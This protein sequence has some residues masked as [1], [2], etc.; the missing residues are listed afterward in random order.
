MF[1]SNQ[2]LEISG[3]YSQLEETLYFILKFEGSSTKN[4]CYQITDDGKY[5]L[6]W[7]PEGKPE[8][9]WTNFQFDFDTEIVSKIIIQTLHKFNAE[10]SGYEW[11]D[12]CTDRGFLMK[13]ILNFFS[14]E[15]EGIK[16]P[17]YGI[18]Y[19][20]PFTNFYAK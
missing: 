2:K 1:S 4:M 10:K 18:V 11:A 13:N 12:G 9:G 19:F 14:D 16:K 3:D 8:N 7:A 20:E 15:W 5:C 6:G 17:F